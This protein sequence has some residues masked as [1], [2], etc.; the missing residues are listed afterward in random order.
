MYHLTVTFLLIDGADVIW[1][2]ESSRDGQIVAVT[3]PN[4]ALTTSLDGDLQ[5][6]ERIGVDSQNGNHVVP[7]EISNRTSAGSNR[8]RTAGD[9]KV[10]NNRR[11]SRPNKRRNSHTG[12]HRRIRD[13][14][15]SNSNRRDNHRT[16]SLNQGHPSRFLAA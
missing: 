10:R 16:D 4:S 15:A 8:R 11:N 12:H 7:R 1:V 6:T 13:T 2:T 5:M 3:T 9:H 14:P